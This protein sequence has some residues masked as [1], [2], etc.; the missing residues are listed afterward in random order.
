MEGIE[1]YVKDE[2]LDKFEISKE[3]EW[4]SWGCSFVLFCYVDLM[5]YLE[6]IWFG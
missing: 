4:F 5:F 1:C 6:W 3:F 2:L